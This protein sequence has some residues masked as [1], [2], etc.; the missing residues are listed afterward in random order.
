VRFFFLG[1][2]CSKWLNAKDINTEMFRDGGGKYLS[3]KAVRSRVHKFS[4]GRSKVADDL[5]YC[6]APLRVFPDIWRLFPN[7]KQFARNAH[8]PISLHLP[9][10]PPWQH[11]RTHAYLQVKHS[12]PRAPGPLSPLFASARIGTLKAGLVIS[13][14][15]VLIML[16]SWVKTV[17][18]AVLSLI[19]GV[20]VIN[21]LWNK[22]FVANKETRVQ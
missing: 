11:S 13:L 16:Q 14:V 5:K 20:T 6:G 17:V 19:G 12:V 18:V 15:F 1:G 10:P 7:R 22:T 8:A 3:C 21:L 9:L 2:G 4:Q